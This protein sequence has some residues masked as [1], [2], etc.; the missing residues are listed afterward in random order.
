MTGEFVQIGISLCLTRA[1]LHPSV[2]SKSR[3][4]SGISLDAEWLPMYDNYATIRIESQENMACSNFSGMKDL[5]HPQI[6]QIT[7]ILKGQICAN[8]RIG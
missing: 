7:Q 1:Y 5:D 2:A 3:E 4:L 8:R 6:E